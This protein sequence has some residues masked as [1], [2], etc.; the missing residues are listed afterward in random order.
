MPICRALV[1]RVG[2][3]KL[4]IHPKV[5]DEVLPCRPGLVAFACV[6][7]RKRATR[8]RVWRDSA[9]VP[10]GA[11]SK[12]EECAA[13]LVPVPCDMRTFRDVTIPQCHLLRLRHVQCVRV[14]L[15][16]KAMGMIGRVRAA[17]RG[18]APCV[19]AD[20]SRFCYWN[21]CPTCRRLCYIRLQTGCGF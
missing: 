4:Y 9:T 7:D 21:L 19:Q 12:P 6:S 10:P 16:T 13:W 11:L 14:Y 20:D 15:R 2:L 1:A 5:G 8:V 3:T 17:K 18:V